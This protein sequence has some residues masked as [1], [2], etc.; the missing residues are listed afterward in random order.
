MRWE[1]NSKPAYSGIWSDT[2]DPLEFLFAEGVADFEIGR[3]EVFC[4][5][6]GA[7]VLWIEFDSSWDT[8][9]DCCREVEKRSNDARLRGRL[10]G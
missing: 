3:E 10:I 7:T 9:S 8:S 1:M 2:V 5:L 6:S 4:G